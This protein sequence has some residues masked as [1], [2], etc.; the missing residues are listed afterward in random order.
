MTMMIFI[1]IPPPRIKLHGRCI[2]AFFPSFLN[3][4]RA[5]PPPQTFTKKR[6]KGE[7]FRTYF[8]LFLFLMIDMNFMLVYIFYPL[9]AAPPP[10]PHFRIRRLVIQGHFPMCALY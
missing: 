3:S 6:K 4:C 10:P 7:N 9:A 1:V 5:A 2:F 8:S